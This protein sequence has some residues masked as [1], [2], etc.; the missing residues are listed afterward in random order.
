MRQSDL[1][2]ADDFDGF[3]FD[4]DGVVYKGTE[5]IEYAAEVINQLDQSQVAFITN[6]AS[7]TPDKVAELLISVGVQAT[8]DQVVTSAQV[9]AD[10]LLDKLGPGARVLVVGAQGLR[11]EVA[12]RGLVVEEDP[13]SKPDAVVQGFSKE[14]TWKDLADGAIAVESGA[15]YLA[16]NLDSTIPTARGIAPGNGTLVRAVTEASG[17][18]PES[19]GKPAP[20]MLTRAMQRLGCSNPLVIGDRL[21]TDIEAANAAGLASLLVLTGITVSDDV[22]GAPAEQQPTYIAEDL[23]GLLS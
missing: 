18:A 10:T 15:Y 23:R 2:L 22:N 14:L 19:V 5:P 9:A 20:T 21:D 17:V 11:D 1:V 6:N 3:L 4:L 13:T 12:A 16:T 8:E 7:R